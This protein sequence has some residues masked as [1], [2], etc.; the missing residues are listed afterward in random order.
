MRY[1]LSCNTLLENH[2]T[3]GYTNDLIKNYKILP[4]KIVISNDVTNTFC[5]MPQG[6]YTALV[7]MS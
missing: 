5:H 3:I 4:L 1:Y 7:E 6:H 2:T